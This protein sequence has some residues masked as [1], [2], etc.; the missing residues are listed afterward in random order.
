MPDSDPE[1]YTACDYSALSREGQPHVV[2]RWCIDWG[3]TFWPLDGMQQHM[4]V[5][6]RDKTQTF[7][8]PFG[9]GCLPADNHGSLVAVRVSDPHAKGSEQINTALVVALEEQVLS[10][11]LVERALRHL[12]AAEWEMAS[13]FDE[14]KSSTGSPIVRASCAPINSLATAYLVIG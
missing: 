2:L 9:L 10:R 14:Q 12:L 5:I 4:A 7:G 1:G 3:Q 8:L 6:V 11:D 13:E